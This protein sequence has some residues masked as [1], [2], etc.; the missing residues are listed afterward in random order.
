M[1]M[2]LKTWSIHCYEE[3]YAKKKEIS[4]TFGCNSTT[5]GNGDTHS[6]NEIWGSWNKHE[7]SLN[8]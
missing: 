3:A 6:T 1:K 8:L 4:G 2:D 5:N 7:A